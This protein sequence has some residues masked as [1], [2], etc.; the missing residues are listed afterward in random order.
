MLLLLLITALSSLSTGSDSPDPGINIGTPP[1]SDTRAVHSATGDTV[2]DLLDS[3]TA[4]IT[5]SSETNP[6]GA[7]PSP[8]GSVG[9]PSAVV[10]VAANGGDTCK[11]DPRDVVAEEYYP[12]R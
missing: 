1:A 10:A 3:D 9:S 12:T 6:V 8:D 5:E 4:L 11:F 2:K 7:T